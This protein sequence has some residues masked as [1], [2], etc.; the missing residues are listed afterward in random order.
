MAIISVICFLFGMAFMFIS[1][2]AGLTHGTNPSTIS[3]LDSLS[4]ISFF[5]S[6]IFLMKYHYGRK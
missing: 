2:L 3:F 1:A 6:C 4:V 5:L